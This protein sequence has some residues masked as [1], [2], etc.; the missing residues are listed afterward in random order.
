MRPAPSPIAPARG[1]PGVDENRNAWDSFPKTFGTIQPYLDNAFRNLF[2]DLR[3]TDEIRAAMDEYQYSPIVIDHF[4][5]PRNRGLLSEADGMGRS[6]EASGEH[7]IFWI[8]VREDAIVDIRFE[9]QGCEAA[10]A[11]ASITTELAKGKHLDDA[12]LIAQD[13]IV[14]ALGGLPA[15]KRHAAGMAA[16]ALSTAILDSV[17]RWVCKAAWPNAPQQE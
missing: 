17:L 2:Y 9:G 5:N 3:F 11:C 10:I 7:V 13:T 1:A 4:E 15:E 14:T 8:Q 6:G 16:E 12:S